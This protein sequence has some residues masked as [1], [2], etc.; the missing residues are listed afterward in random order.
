MGGGA[1]FIRP[2]KQLLQGAIFV[3]Y[4]YF[5]QILSF[6]QFTFLTRIFNA[7]FPLLVPNT[8][9][10]QDMQEVQRRHQFSTCKLIISFKRGLHPFY[11]PSVEVVRPHLRGLTAAAVASHP[12]L[13][14]GTW[15]PLR[16]IG[17]LIGKIKTFL[18]VGR[19]ACPPARNSAHM[20]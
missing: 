17:E 3:S 11:P 1:C 10:T 19:C 4:G 7:S 16:P 14:L 6:T 5:C 15:D 9:P 18:E 20:A 8:S 13:K 12:L 2:R